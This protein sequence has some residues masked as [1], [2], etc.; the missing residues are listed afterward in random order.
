MPGTSLSAGSRWAHFDK[1]FSI[2]LFLSNQFCTFQ[3]GRWQIRIKGCSKS[4]LHDSMTMYALQRGNKPS[5]ISSAWVV[6]KSSRI[7]QSENRMNKIIWYNLCKISQ[8]QIA[9]LFLQ[10]GTTP[11]KKHCRT[12]A[13]H[14]PNWPW[15]PMFKMPPM[16]PS[17]YKPHQLTIVAQR[18]WWILLV[19]SL[20]VSSHSSSIMCFFLENG[21]MEVEFLLGLPERNL[22]LQI[23][24]FNLLNNSK[25]PSGWRS[26]S[27][28]SHQ[29]CSSSFLNG[30][31]RWTWH[32]DCCGQ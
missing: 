32:V 12:A 26:N 19:Y 31:K 30:L 1:A 13:L 29:I 7:A 27:N 21:H 25:C 24:G 22:Q 14:P 17:Q 3:T 28:F 5:F 9:R 23:K 16:G 6:P 4:Y 8:F 10:F 2:P 18:W 11:K 20:R 15:G